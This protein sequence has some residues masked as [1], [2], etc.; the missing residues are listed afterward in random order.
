MR[1]ENDII[2]DKR[3]PWMITKVRRDMSL[4]ENQLPFFVLENLFKFTFETQLET[5]PSLL[6]LAYNFF[7]V[8]ANLEAKPGTERMFDSKVKHLLDALRFWHLPTPQKALDFKWEKIEAIPRAKQLQAAGVKFRMSKSNCLFDIKFSKGV[9]EIPCF[10]LNPTT[11]SFL[12]NIMAFEQSCYRHDSYFID[13]VAF[14]GDLIKTRADV[15]LLIEKG[16]IA[17]ENL[18][19]NEEI[20]ANNDET[21]ANLFNSFGKESRF[22]TANIGFCSLSAASESLL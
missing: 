19:G 21:L 17:T 14:L 2:F 7:C 8:E 18:L 20:L 15:K 16:I 5:L 6:E 4:M 22:W 13:Y 10:K 11:E 3:K 1:A 9:L 12:R